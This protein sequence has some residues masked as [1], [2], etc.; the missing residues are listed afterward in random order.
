MIQR[1]SILL[2]DP[3]LILNAKMRNVNSTQMKSMDVITLTQ[4]RFD[5]FVRS[6]D[7]DDLSLVY[8]S[9]HVALASN[10]NSTM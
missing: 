10:R 9:L 8:T 3:C 6:N 1:I 2:A 5:E 4:L 7:M